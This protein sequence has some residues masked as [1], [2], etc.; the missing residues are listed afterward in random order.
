MRIV[1]YDFADIAY[2][3]FFINGFIQNEREFGYRFTV[4]KRV[5]ALMRDKEMQGPSSGLLPSIL[6]FEVVEHG[7]TFYFCVDAR[8]GS[9]RG[10]EY[11]EGYHV[12]LLQ[13]VD[14]YFKVNYVLDDILHDPVLEKHQAKIVPAGPF[15]ALRVPLRRIGLPRLRPADCM[16]WKRSDIRR[17]LRSLRSG[18]TLDDLRRLRTTP[19][20]LDVFFVV[21][22]YTNPLH[23]HDNEL[24]YNIIK[25]I[26]GHRDLRS[27]TGLA[28]CDGQSLPG[29]Y[30]EYQCANYGFK[31]YLR[32]RAKSRVAIYVRGLHSALSPKFGELLAMGM[33]IVGQRIKTNTARLYRNQVFKSQFAYEEPRVI[34]E[35]LVHVLADPEQLRM[36]GEENART[37]DASLTPRSVVSDILRELKGHD[38]TPLLRHVGYSVSQASSGPM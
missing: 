26:R 18:M 34:V 9:K 17:R 10:A 19:K 23:A 1:Y 7:K 6:I 5:P 21:R 4:S 20:E 3:S 13:R 12:P 16:H 37:F 33:P 15:F 28:S 11:G 8:D 14:H 22:Y 31:S 24:R 32:H 38:E 36:F 2:S 35:R 30:A 27:V 25:E 29:K